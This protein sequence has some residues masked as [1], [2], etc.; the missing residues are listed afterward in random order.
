MNSISKLKKL[1]DEHFDK[2]NKLTNSYKKKINIIVVGGANLNNDNPQIKENKET[3]NNPNQ[4]KYSEMIKFKEDLEAKGYEI[5]ICAVDSD[6]NFPDY[7]IDNLVNT[8]DIKDNTIITHYKGSF[9]FNNKKFLKENTHN[10]IVTFSNSILPNHNNVDITNINIKDYKITYIDCSGANKDSSS[11]WNLGFPTNVIENI[12]KYDLTTPLDINDYKSYINVINTTKQLKE[13]NILKV[14]KPYIRA[15]W[16][17]LVNLMYNNNKNNEI[18]CKEL[19]KMNQELLFNNDSHKI[20]T[21]FKNKKIDN[22]INQF[23]I[24]G[25]KNFHTLNIET[26][27]TFYKIVY[28]VEY[29]DNNI[30]RNVLEEI[31]FKEIYKDKE[32][33]KDDLEK[34]INKDQEW[35]DLNEKTRKS[36]FEL[37]YGFEYENNDDELKF[38]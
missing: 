27:K 16:Y 34:F 10:I 25:Y 23:I 4:C 28:N 13:N 6:Y 24:N 26:I 18:I 1:I 2:L 33:I 12:I 21:E 3:W 14:M 35:N 9:K 22:D 38:E 37:V 5:S 15:S 32:F 36:F 31:K 30:L 8:I 17:I 29:F 20:F 11:L 7:T 19:K